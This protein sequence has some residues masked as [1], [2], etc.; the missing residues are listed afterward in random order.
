VHRQGT[1]IYVYIHDYADI[2]ELVEELGYAVG[3]INKV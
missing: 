2:Q 1:H 3:G